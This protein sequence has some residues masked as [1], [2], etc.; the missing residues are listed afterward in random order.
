MADREFTPEEIQEAADEVRQREF[1]DFMFMDPSRYIGLMDDETAEQR[2]SSS[3]N[4]RKSTQDNTPQRLSPVQIL[5]CTEWRY[6]ADS[7]L[8]T[9]SCWQD[10]N[11]QELRIRKTKL[12]KSSN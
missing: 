4:S 5:T 3:T 7:K 9:K 12:L 8:E 2:T 11:M 6:I 10:G 1:G